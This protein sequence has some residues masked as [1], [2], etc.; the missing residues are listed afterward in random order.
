MNKARKT[1]STTPISYD[2]AMA[3]FVEAKNAR[4]EGAG[5]A[6]ELRGTLSELRSAITAA[7]RDEDFAKAGELKTRRDELEAL[8]SRGAMAKLAK[9]VS[10]AADALTAV[11]FNEHPEHVRTTKVTLTR[12][13]VVNPATNH[14]TNV[15]YTDSGDTVNLSLDGR[16]FDSEAYHLGSWALEHGYLVHTNQVDVQV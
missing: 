14:S 11:Y 6:S 13:T 15:V 10:A 16:S 3:A 4:D 7:V 2:A 12:V 1:A 5:R 8:V 9:A